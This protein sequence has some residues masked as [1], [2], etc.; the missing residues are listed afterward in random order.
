MTSGREVGSREQRVGGCKMKCV[1]SECILGSGLK[2]YFSLESAYPRLK[3]GVNE[4]EMQG[5]VGVGSCQVHF[6][7]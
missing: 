6:R 3:P 4:E 1:H 5:K 2:P 7:S